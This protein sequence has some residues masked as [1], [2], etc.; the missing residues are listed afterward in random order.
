MISEKWGYL[1]E[2]DK[3][4]IQHDEGEC[5]AA[6]QDLLRE[7]TSL[8]NQL[9]DIHAMG[10]IIANEYCYEDELPC[11]LTA[12]L[13]SK[14]VVDGVRLY[15]WRAVAKQLEAD[16]AEARDM[17]FL[18]AKAYDLLERASGKKDKFG[19]EAQIW[20]MQYEDALALQ[21]PK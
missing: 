4:D 10:D 6:I 3:D 2:F 1:A 16:L 7:N 12:E 20:C 17:D 19:G 11:E 13:F 9:M 15:P 18:L 8:L 14:S 21:D 5:L